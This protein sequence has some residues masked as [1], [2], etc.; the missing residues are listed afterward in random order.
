[1]GCNSCKNKNKTKNIEK[2]GNNKPNSNNVDKSNVTK[3]KTKLTLDKLAVK[4]LVTISKIIIYLIGIGISIPIII[5]FTLYILFKTIFLNKGVDVSGALLAIGKT[6]T[7]KRG[8]AEDYDDDYDDAEYDEADFEPV[9]VED[10]T[11]KKS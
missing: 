2:K 1:M 11:D 6:I 3:S 8:N 7:N 4:I 5:P 10:I 9:G